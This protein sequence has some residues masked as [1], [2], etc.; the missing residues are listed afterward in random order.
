MEK[1]HCICVM[2]DLFRA[3]S[4]MEANLVNDYDLSLNEAMI[5]C[6][7]GDDCLTSTAISQNIGLLPSHTSKTLR[8]IETKGLAKRSMG[9]EDKRQMYFTLTSKGKKRLAKLKENGL[10]VPTYLQPFFHPEQCEQ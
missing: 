6:C 1:V 2:R 9:K 3:F 10:A 5:L 8:S 4:E 7:V